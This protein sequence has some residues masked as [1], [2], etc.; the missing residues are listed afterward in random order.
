MDHDE[1]VA[2]IRELHAQG[3]STNAITRTLGVKRAEVAAVVRGLTEASSSPP[4]GP[5]LVGC[6]VSA[7]WSIGLGVPEDRSWPDDPAFGIEASGMVGVLVAREHPRRR[8]SVTVCGYLLDV[9]CLGVKDAL[10]PRLMGASSLKRFR[11]EY[12]AAFPG[13]E[14]VVSPELVA[15][16][17][18]GA[19]AYARGLGFEPHADFAAAARHVPELD[20]DS[21]IT[22][23]RHG[24]PT[25]VQGPFDRPDHILRTLD[26]NV[27]LDNV[28]FTITGSHALV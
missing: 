24:R 12:F 26:A 17:V 1:L 18:W 25:Y 5:A 19:A 28:T 20:G 9:Y 14:V 13:G 22:F 2:R 7:G 15:H 8:G 10:G 21:V 6:W 4:G 16:L 3:Q 27:G 23:G 11:R